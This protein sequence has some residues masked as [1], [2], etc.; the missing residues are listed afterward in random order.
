MQ[1]SQNRD[2]NYV[3]EFLKII[4]MFKIWGWNVQKLLCMQRWLPSLQFCSRDIWA[5]WVLRI[6]N[7][8]WKAKSG[9]VFFL[10]WS[11]LLPLLL[12]DLC[13]ES[14]PPH[15][16]YISFFVQPLLFLACLLLLIL[17]FLENPSPLIYNLTFSYFPRLFKNY[18]LQNPLP[19]H[20]H[21]ICIGYWSLYYHSTLWVSLLL[22]G[23]WCGTSTFYFCLSHPLYI[24]GNLRLDISSHPYL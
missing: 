11:C 12:I 5:Y 7:D 10:I 14:Y 6:Q 21:Q 19:I 22:H 24:D 4:C 8:G 18:H 15:M 23:P 17:F 1:S 13:F 3:T 16:C 9:L 20:D 2:S